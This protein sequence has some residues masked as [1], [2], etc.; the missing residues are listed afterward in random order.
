VESLLNVLAEIL[1]YSPL[2]VAISRFMAWVLS[3]F[4]SATVIQ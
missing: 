4:V 3:T 1:V 2:D